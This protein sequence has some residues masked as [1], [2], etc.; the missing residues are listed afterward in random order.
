MTWL[1]KKIF[2]MVTIPCTASKVSKNGVFSGPYFPAF[3]LNTERYEVSLRILSVFS[4]NAGK[5]EPEKTPHLDNFQALL[6]RFL[7]YGLN[8]YNSINTGTSENI[9]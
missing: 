3:G 4:P 5:Y 9:L 6:T 1:E 7:V 8:K 2:Q